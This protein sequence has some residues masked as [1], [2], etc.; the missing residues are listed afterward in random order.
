MTRQA[1]DSVST[2]ALVRISQNA[3]FVLDSRNSILSYEASGALQAILKD[4][5]ELLQGDR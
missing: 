2:D 5:R 4:V 3:Q 1:L